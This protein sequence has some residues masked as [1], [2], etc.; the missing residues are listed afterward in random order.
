[1]I[2]SILNVL[3]GWDGTPR[4]SFP[5]NEVNVGVCYTDPPIRGVLFHPQT[6]SSFTANKARGVLPHTVCPFQSSL[7]GI[8]KESS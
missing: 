4:A 8:A 1:M 3:Q 7:Q 5:G 2:A 6:F